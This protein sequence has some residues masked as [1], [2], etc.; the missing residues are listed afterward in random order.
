MEL[1]IQERPRAHFIKCTETTMTSRAA[2]EI[3]SS[4]A[5]RAQGLPVISAL[6]ADKKDSARALEPADS[7]PVS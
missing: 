3:S 1:L 2:S 5:P 7:F 6:V 4:S